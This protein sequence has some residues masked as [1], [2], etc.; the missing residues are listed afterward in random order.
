MPTLKIESHKTVPVA[1]IEKMH[2]LIDGIEYGMQPNIDW[3]LLVSN[4]QLESNW[5]ALLD[6]E[7]IGFLSA[8]Y[9]VDHQADI[10]FF[11]NPQAE[12]E[13]V[14]SQL[15]LKA[16]QYFETVSVNQLQ[17]SISASNQFDLAFM[18]KM[19]AKYQQS[20]L[21]MRLELSAYDAKES[22]GELQVVRLDQ[23]QQ[24]VEIDVQCFANDAVHVRQ[25][26]EQTFNDTSRQ[27]FFYLLDNKR[28]GKC[29]LKMSYDTVWLHDI[30]VLPDF[31]NQ[32]IGC[33][34]LNALLI[35]LARESKLKYIALFVDQTNVHAK[36]LYDRLGFVIK[37]V[38]EYWL[39]AV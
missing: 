6:N 28:V 5:F 7:L 34:M 18:Q 37:R 2:A 14:F 9:Y 24:L 35:Q 32:G 3:S 17:F 22:E 23:L 15:L 8:A 39:F 12:C 33:S 1:L 4:R 11:I 25:R 10:M 16:C 38:D 31:Q 21:L 29:H 19:H 20:E 26:F 27:A 36:Q 13:F 30:A